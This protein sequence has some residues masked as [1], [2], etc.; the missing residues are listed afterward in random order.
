M[1]FVT[2]LRMR[3]FEKFDFLELVLP[4]DAARVFAGGARF[5]A[6]AGSP[7]GHLNWQFVFREG[8]VAIKVVKFHFAGGRKPEIGVLNL[9]E[10]S[11]KFW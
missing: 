10:V 3:E 6:E 11:G 2:F 5:G 9:E 7:S 8:L 4:Q 1:F